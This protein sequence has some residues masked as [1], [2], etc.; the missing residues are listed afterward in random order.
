MKRNR[1]GENATS[2]PRPGERRERHLRLPEVMDRVGLKRTAIHQRMR[3]GRFPKSRSLGTRY[4]V[5]FEFEIDDWIGAIYQ[6]R[7]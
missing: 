4:T 3:D 2:E 7:P 5:R 6:K 1:C